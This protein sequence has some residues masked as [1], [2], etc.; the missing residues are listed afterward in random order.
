MDR[1]KTHFINSNDGKGK[2]LCYMM[3]DTPI[4]IIELIRDN[5]EKIEEELLKYGGILFR[6]FNIRSLSEFNKLANVIIPNLLDYE[7]RSTP[8]TKL[9]GKIY[10][11]TEYP[12]NRRIPFHNENSYTLKWPSK[13]LFFSVLVAEEGGETAIADSRYVYENIDKH[14]INE[15]N[16]KK[17]LY[18]RNY[19]TGVDLSWQEV[20][21]TEKKEEVENYCKGNEI[22]Y[23]WGNS[24]IELT[25][26]QV[27]QATIQ[28]PV[29]KENIWF[30]QAHLFNKSY[31]KED[32]VE[33]L[34]QLFGKGKFSR[35]SYYGDGSEIPKNYFDT[36]NSAYKK[37]KIEFKWAKGDVM[38][39]D[40][41]LMAHS[42]N[43]YKGNRKVVVA[44]GY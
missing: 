14:I 16:N 40:N 26:K 21:Q 15:F 19:M 32:E 28:H 33:K 24:D 41:V 42:R 44:M 10:T 9:G 34:E 12:P 5:K 4:D 38:L 22:S 6:G 20:F 37:E 8:R 31:L 27:C 39:L 11:S 17:I 3:H 13:I 23:Q 2:I 1:L 25:T 30:N 18:V 36:I 29:T 43:P 7:N 35:N